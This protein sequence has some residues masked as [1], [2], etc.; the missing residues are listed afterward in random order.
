MPESVA[1]IEAS[2]LKQPRPHAFRIFRTTGSSF[3]PSRS[4][5]MFENT[6]KAA[7]AG[8]APRYQLLRQTKG[9]VHSSSRRAST[10]VSLAVG[11]GRQGLLTESSAMEDG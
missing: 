6:S 8:N 9:V 5:Y 2:R 3:A 4:L 1:T 11:N 7:V 10:G